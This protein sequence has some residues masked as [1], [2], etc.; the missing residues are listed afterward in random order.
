MAM[1]SLG[2]PLICSK[3][4][5][6]QVHAFLDEEFFDRFLLELPSARRKTVPFHGLQ[7]SMDVGLDKK[8][9]AIN[10]IDATCS[11]WRAGNCNNDS[12]YLFRRS[13]LF[14]WQPGG[15]L[16]ELFIPGS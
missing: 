5:P 11:K 9:T 7:V 16:A 6:L 4:L 8:G 12:G 13:N 2:M 3:N 15:C 1:I 14:G 10:M